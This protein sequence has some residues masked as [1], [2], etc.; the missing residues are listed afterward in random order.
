[1]GGQRWHVLI[2]LQD[3]EQEDKEMLDGELLRQIQG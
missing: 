3:E 2:N 1:M